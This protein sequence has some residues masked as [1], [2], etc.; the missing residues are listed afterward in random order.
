MSHFQWD[1]KDNAAI[2]CITV[3]NIERSFPST[4]TGHA[5]LISILA[6]YFN[7]LT[8]QLQ[9]PITESAQLIIII[10]M[11]IIIIIIM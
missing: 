5:M 4:L 11:M 7:V 10:I 8:Q 3:Q 9:E 6:L 1:L 2:N